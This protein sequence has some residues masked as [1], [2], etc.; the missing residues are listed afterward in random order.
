MSLP[1]RLWLLFFTFF[2]I[3]LF[4]VGGGLAML[5]VIEQTFSQKQKC[6][7]QEDILDM[8]ILTQTVPGLIAVNAA[9]YVGYKVAGFI[10]AIVAVIGVILPSVL[11]IMAIAAFFPNL[12][13]KNE[14]VI[15]TFSAIRACVTGVLIATAFRLIC[16]I[17]R[18]KWDALLVLIFC[19]LL[20]ARVNPILVIIG[21]MPIGCLLV[22]YEHH[23]RT[24]P[25]QSK[26]TPH[27]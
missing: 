1:Q 11:I 13:F 9:L 7:T 4:V 15:H 18:T 25:E 24:F 19:V 22:W 14:I 3:A 26:E 5:P 23:R 17:V 20:I 16:K 2:K 27:A 12:N 21:S 10:G 6:L 8:V